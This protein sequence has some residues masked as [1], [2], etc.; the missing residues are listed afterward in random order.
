VFGAA[1][2]ECVVFSF[3]MHDWIYNFVAVALEVLAKIFLARIEKILLIKLA[4]PSFIGGQ[5]L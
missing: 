3:S 1:G 5:L 2:R 4:C